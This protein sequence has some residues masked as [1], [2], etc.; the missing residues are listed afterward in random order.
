MEPRTKPVGRSVCCVV[1]CAI[2]LGHAASLSV[3]YRSTFVDLFPCYSIFFVINGSTMAV[4]SG[5]EHGVGGGGVS[6]ATRL[7]GSSGQQQGQ[8]DLFKYGSAIPLSAPAPL[9]HPFLFLMPHI[10][11][12]LAARS[13]LE[14]Q[15]IHWAHCLFVP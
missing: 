13:A 12:H 11:W 10:H 14:C 8:C 3:E 4:T 5:C 6:W 1:R 9:P 15:L 7:A 2:S